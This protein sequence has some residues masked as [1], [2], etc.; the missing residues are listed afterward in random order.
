MYN[1]E[2]LIVFVSCTFRYD[3]PIKFAIFFLKKTIILDW[4][5]PT[6]NRD[7]EHQTRPCPIPL[8]CLMAMVSGAWVMTGGINGG[9]NFFFFSLGSS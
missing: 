4:Q 8:P 3:S 6:P 9:F 5:Y 2:P 1:Y 7:K